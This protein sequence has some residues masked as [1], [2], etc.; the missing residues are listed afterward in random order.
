MLQVVADPR[1]AEIR[2]LRAEVETL[3]KAL[4]IALRDRPREP[5]IVPNY[6]L[7]PMIRY[8]DT[9]PTVA[10]WWEM[11][12]GWPLPPPVTCRTSPIR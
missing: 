12:A 10:P 11:P 6:D 2:R 4:E 1:D 7:P 5:E 3:K 8:G 9:A